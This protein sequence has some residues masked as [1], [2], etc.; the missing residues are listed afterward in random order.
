MSLSYS[1]SIWHFAESYKKRNWANFSIKDPPAAYLLNEGLIIE[2]KEIR[3]IT[4]KQVCLMLMK[5]NRVIRE[6]EFFPKKSPLSKVN[7]L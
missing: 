4:S 6:V 2:S 3:P 1:F 7:E 5:K